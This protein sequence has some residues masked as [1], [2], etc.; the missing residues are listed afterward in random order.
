MKLR[1]F[2]LALVIGFGILAILALILL[3]TASPG[4]SQTNS[5]T[6]VGPVQ[7]WGTLPAPA[8]NAVIAQLADQ[9]KDF[10]SVTYRFV[11]AEQFNE[12]LVEALADGVGPDLI[13]ISQEHLTEQRK[14][15]RPTAYESYPIRDFRDLYLDGAQVFALSDGV[16]GIP[17]L[18]DPLVMYWNKDALTNAGFLTPP[19]T[20]EELVNV[21]LP[22]LI[23]RSFDRTINKAVVAFGVFNNT[24]NAF[25]TLSMLLIQ[26]GS[27]LVSET[28]VEEGVKYSV[29]LNT[30]TNARF[31]LKSILDFF[32]R[33]S[34]PTN[35]LY[36]WNRS[37]AS[38]K[39]E[40]IAEDLIFYFGYASEGVE[41][42]R[43]NPNLNF[44]IAEVP[45]GADAQ[46]RRTY[47]QFY[48]LAA[49]RS[50]DNLTGAYNALNRLTSDAVVPTLATELHMVPAKRS[51]V[52]NG[53]ND[54]Y[55]RLAY[56]TA[57]IAFGWLSPQRILV[58]QVFA[59]TLSD[60]SENRID[61]DKGAENA[62]SKISKLYD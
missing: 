10:E 50:S 31:P 15:I 41:L 39:S 57:P 3:A 40:F 27:N 43:L 14:R 38:D 51:L 48:A 5:E 44:D 47:G 9:D 28:V 59:S 54:V 13:L 34:Q 12:E 29:S 46:V 60:V 30:G 16:Y 21:Q 42:Q 18:V 55:G 56:R 8:I 7:I 11:A 17:L 61:V 4:G 1:P 35:T 22:A 58:D 45:Q 32:L 53:S 62:E 33:F 24:E 37:F 2:E 49:L 19:K 20:W 6:Y 36:S 23:N 52:A 26:S 25:A